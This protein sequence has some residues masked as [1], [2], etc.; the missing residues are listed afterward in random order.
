MKHRLTKGKGMVV[1]V[2]GKEGKVLRGGKVDMRARAVFCVK[3]I[4]QKS[5][6]Q[7]TALRK[8]NGTLGVEANGT[9]KLERFS[10][11]APKLCV[12]VA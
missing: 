5:K 12:R 4:L 6:S 2:W 3:V 7:R 9:V 1:A 8:L 10:L 11:V